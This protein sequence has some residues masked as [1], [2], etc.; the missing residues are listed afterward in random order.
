[1]P[2]AQYDVL[3]WLANRMSLPQPQKLKHVVMQGKRLSN[4]RLMESGYQLQYPN[5]QIGYAELV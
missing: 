2:T 3:S 1:M 4:S 5:Y